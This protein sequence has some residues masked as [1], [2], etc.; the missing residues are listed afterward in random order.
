MKKISSVML[1]L[2]CLLAG[3]LLAQTETRYFLVEGSYS[4]EALAHAEVDKLKAGGFPAEIVGK[5]SQGNIRVSYYS[6]A[7]KSDAMEQLAKLKSQNKQSWI[8]ES[9][10][11][12]STAISTPATNT[13]TTQPG[14]T[15]VVKTEK[16]EDIPAVSNK[17]VITETIS[18]PAPAETVT[19]TETAETPETTN[20]KPAAE[21]Q[22]TPPPATTTTTTT[23]PTPTPTPA[24]VTT[25]PVIST[26][27]TSVVETSKVPQPSAQASAAQAKSE[28]YAYIKTE[29]CVLCYSKFCAETPSG[30][31]SL[32]LKLINTSSAPRMVSFVISWKT[33]SSSYMESRSW[34]IEP[35][36][37]DT[38]ISAADPDTKGM[39]SSA[40]VEISKVENKDKS[41]SGLDD[42]SGN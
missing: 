35:N 2:F 10:A 20:I 31:A 21:T 29:H 23:T 42:C 41:L 17:P 28:G 6:F 38:V 24:P 39:Q 18:T 13:T 12:A 9:K 16:K 27:V 32:N 7:S 3:N 30:L 33:G 37:T 25:T 34:L 8:L 36:A 40:S 14:S 26:P 19:K 22:T 1:A 15:A 11:V 4:T 5:N